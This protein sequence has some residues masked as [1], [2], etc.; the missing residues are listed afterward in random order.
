MVVAGRITT[1]Q[2]AEFENRLTLNTTEIKSTLWR[3]DSL[4]NGFM[5]QLNALSPGITQTY[6]EMSATRNPFVS[7]LF[8]LSGDIELNP[9][10]DTRQATLTRT[11]ELRS[12]ANTDETLTD[13]LKDIQTNIRELK[14][15]TKSLHK[16]IEKMETQL[17]NMEDAIDEVRQTAEGNKERLKKMESLED[18]VIRIEIEMK[19][20]QTAKAEMEDRSKRNNL[21]FRGVQEDEN[22]TWEETEQKVKS[23]L[24][25]KMNI[26]DDIE[27]ERVHR[28][29]TGTRASANSTGRPIVAMCS[30]YKDKEKIL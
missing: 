4:C 25:E 20:L 1:F 7:R 23:L 28:M 29:S 8:Q 27:F 9:G 30:K 22:E 17:N 26:T 10:P 13:I 16:K 18:D 5:D 19:K 21:V 15:D 24:S 11:G 3:V 12:A 6:T 2:S 14:R